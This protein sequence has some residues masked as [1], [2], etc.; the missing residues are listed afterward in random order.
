L[1]IEVQTGPVLRVAAA[2]A[3]LLSFGSMAADTV[4]TSLAQWHIEAEQ[5][6]RIDIRGGVLDIDVPGGTTL[7]L[8]RELHAPVAIEYEVMAVSEG[9][10]N[11]RVSDVNAFWMATNKDGSS[12]LGHRN[13]TFEQYNNLLTYYV[14]I[15][16]N[17]NSTTRMRRYIGERDERPLRPEHDLSGADTL[18]TANRWQKVRLVADGQGAEVW[19]DGKRLF[20]IDDAQPYTHGWFA[21]RTVKSH[22]RIRNLTIEANP[23]RRP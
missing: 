2:L 13:G 8:K 20:R 4:G 9:G 19:Q 7:W 12:P 5:G 18:L 10:A 14:G 11:D 1:R 23:S 21:I 16:G 3:L 15:G 17:S 22:L 6:A